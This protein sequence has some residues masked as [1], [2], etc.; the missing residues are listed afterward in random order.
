MSDIS[1]LRASERRRAKML[2][3]MSHDL[4]SPLVST[5]ALTQIA[6]LKPER[7]TDGKT[8]KRI[9]TNVRKTLEIVDDFLHMARA[10]ST[11]MMPKDWV[12]LST[13][14]DAAVDQVAAQAEQKSISL[15]SNLDSARSKCWGSTGCWNAQ[16]SI[17]SPM[18]SNLARSTQVS[19]SR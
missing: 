7:L 5:L 17:C 16:C 9:E 13:C 3:F 1:E 19:Q 11:D 6:A 14:A 2:S 15:T 10:E 4:R 18:Q 12:V 8:V